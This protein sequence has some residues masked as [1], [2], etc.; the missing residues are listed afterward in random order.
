M[1]TVE[2]IVKVRVNPIGLSTALWSSGYE[3]SVTYEEAR[4]PVSELLEVTTKP[5]LEREPSFHGIKLTDDGWTKLEANIR[6]AKR[7][8]QTKKPKKA[9]PKQ[10]PVV[11][12][13]RKK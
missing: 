9:K 6:A 11:A 10:E 13:K 2:Q 1:A 8:K 7:K 5:M 12:P 3:M 4:R